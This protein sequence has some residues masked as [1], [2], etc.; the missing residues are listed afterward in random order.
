MRKSFRKVLIGAFVLSAVFAAWAWFRPYE[1]GA[2]KGA[3]C[4]VLGC[5]VKQDRTN[6]WVDVHLKMRSAE[7]HDLMKP[8]LLLTSAGRK[9]EPADTTMV[10]DN[11]VKMRELWFKFWLEKE[12]MEGGLKLQI[13]DG[14]LSVRS[15]RGLPLLG[16]DGMRYFV[17]D[18]W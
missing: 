3:H 4:R 6:Y 10:G 18:H 17:T 11:E 8:V 5:Q 13:N 12:D 2:D 1:W 14:Q 7:E 16:D 15:S 9:L